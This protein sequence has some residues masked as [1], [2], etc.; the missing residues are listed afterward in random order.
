VSISSGG[1]ALRFRFRPGR[2]LVAAAAAVLGA[3]LVASS[4]VGAPVPGRAMAIGLGA[5]GLV[6]AVLYLVSPAWRTEVVVDDD[7]LEVLNRGDRRFRLAWTDI[8]RVVAAPASATAFVDGGEP[9]RSL[10]LPGPGARAPYRIAGQR[11][12]F[13]QIRARVPRERVTEVDR[14]NRAPVR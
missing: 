1:A 14:L 2:P 13:D 12:L 4:L 3:G 8:V 11:E 5:V 10:L 6:L 9:A 7:G